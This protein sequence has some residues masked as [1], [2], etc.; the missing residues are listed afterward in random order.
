MSTN[1][2][3]YCHNYLINKLGKQNQHKSSLGSVNWSAMQNPTLAHAFKYRN[4]AL[5][6][7][8]LMSGQC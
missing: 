8:L 2:R 5:A 4:D 1:Q 3:V 6:T 7:Y